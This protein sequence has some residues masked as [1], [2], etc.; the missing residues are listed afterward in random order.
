M[1]FTQPLGKNH[2]FDTYWENTSLDKENTDMSF[3]RSGSSARV[4]FEARRSLPPN[5]DSQMTPGDRKLE[6]LR[7]KIRC[8]ESKLRRAE[9]R[10]ATNKE[11]L[12]E[13]A[14]EN[15][16]TRQELQDAMEE[17]EAAAALSATL[18]QERDQYHAWWINEVKFCQ[19][20]LGNTTQWYHVSEGSTSSEM[21]PY[22]V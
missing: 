13:L 4:P 12:L 11:R 8:L 19:Y 16:K 7:E 17:G 22:L 6:R 21:V 1:N 3:A 9:R 5:R 20:L 2:A 10:E 15:Q 14:L 18:K